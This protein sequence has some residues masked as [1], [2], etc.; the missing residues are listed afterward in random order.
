MRN[1]AKAGVL[2]GVCQGGGIPLFT[3]NGVDIEVAWFTPQSEYR[4]IEFL[5]AWVK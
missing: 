3:A 4:P 1:M 5:Q 2:A